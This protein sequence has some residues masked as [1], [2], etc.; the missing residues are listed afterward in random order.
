[1]MSYDGELWINEIISYVT[2]SIIREFSQKS[3]LPA[4]F[5]S[6]DGNYDDD[7]NIIINFRVSNRYG[8]IY[9]FSLLFMTQEM[10]SLYELRRKFKKVIEEVQSDYGKPIILW[11]SV[12]KVGHL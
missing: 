6:L 9:N 7:F 8:E 2:T 5:D 11:N 12:S 4:E 10:I 3:S 1:M